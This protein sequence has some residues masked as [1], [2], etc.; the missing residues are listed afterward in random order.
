MHQLYKPLANL[1]YRR[2]SWIVLVFIAIGTFSVGAQTVGTGGTESPFE[3][4]GSAM[5]LGMGGAVGAISGYGEAF[6]ENPAVLATVQDHEIL[7]FHA[8]LFLDTIYDSIGYI[9][10]IGT[11]SGFGLSIT[12]LGVSNILQT[13]NNIQAISTFSSE[14]YEGLLGYGF[15]LLPDLDFGANV[16]YVFE[17]LGSYQGSGGGMDLGLLFHFS[18]NH[19]DFNKIGIDNI[20]LGFSETNVI[21]PQTELYQVADSP[22]RVYRPSFS[23]Y[24][25]FLR[26]QSDLWLTAEEEIPDGGQNLFKGGLQYGWNRTVFVRAGFNGNG[27]T[28]GAGLSFFDFEFDY[29]YDQQDLGDLS[30]FSLTYRFDHFVDPLQIQKNFLLKWV[31]RFYTKD[32]DFDAAI[33]AWKNVLREFP[34]DKEAAQGILDVEQQRK[35]LVQQQLKIAQ[36]DLDRGDY[37]DAVPLIAKALSLDPDNTAPKALLKQVDKKTL[38][39]SNYTMGTEAYIRGDYALAVQ[40]LKIV[41]EI[42]SKYRDVDFLLHDAQSYYL[43][44]ATLPKDLTVLYAKGVNYYLAGKY[45]KAIEIWE[46]VL[47]QNPKNFLVRRNIEEASDRLRDF[48]PENSSSVK[49]ESKKK[50]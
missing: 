22:A 44:L 25:Q 46:Q 33:K 35:I 14:E 28:V 6:Y 40:H 3:L 17:Q 12:R 23:Y 20:A 24:Y 43:P 42:D 11:T 41:Y 8:P 34:D 48:V 7:T 10:P 50:P 37:G 38:L 26:S 13:T 9:N 18:K 36:S 30:Q 21:A 45:K 19:S 49:R 39:E 47:S 2:L 29:A 15:S 1:S 32:Q 27:A 4:G 16:K 5:A 31:A